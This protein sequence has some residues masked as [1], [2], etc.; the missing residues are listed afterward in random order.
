VIPDLVPVPRVQFLTLRGSSRLYPLFQ[1]EN[2]QE[3]ELYS[4]F[5]LK[6]SFPSSLTSLTMVHTHLN[7]TGGVTCSVLESLQ[8]L[9]IKEAHVEGQLSAYIHA[10]NLRSFTFEE[11]GYSK[12]KHSDTTFR[13]F[14][15]S[16]PH[17]KEVYMVVKELTDLLVENLGKCPSLCCWSVREHFEKFTR[18]SWLNLGTSSHL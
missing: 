13:D 16:K 18:L 1:L 6:A 5:Q 2:L 4:I 10:P 11:D 7:S 17:L 8:L 15:C 14:F 9:S 3:L 12:L